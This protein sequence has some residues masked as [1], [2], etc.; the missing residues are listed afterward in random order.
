MTSLRLI[1]ILLC[2]ASPVLAQ[3]TNYVRAGASGAN[4]GSDWA[5]A[6]TSF[7]EPLVR[8]VTYM[9]ADGSHPLP[10]LNTANS[11][12]DR[13]TILKATIANHGTST[14]WDNAYGDGQA[15]LGSASATRG[16]YTIDGQTRNATNWNS[17]YGFKM[18]QYYN[19]ADGAANA[20]HNL[21]LRH[22]EF[23]LDDYIGQN[24]CTN[25][26]TPLYFRGSS[27]KTNILIENCYIRQH[28]FIQL[29]GVDGI[30][31][32]S[33]ALAFGWKKEAIRG[34]YTAKNGVIEW[35]RFYRA[36]NG[37]KDENGGTCVDAGENSH[38]GYIAIWDEVGGNP[39]DNWRIENNNF[40]HSNTVAGDG[41]N[42]AI[43]VGGGTGWNGDPANNVAI[44][45]NTLSGW[46]A[47]NAR[48]IINGGDSAG[49]G[50]EI[51][52][53]GWHDCTET[54]VSTANVTQEGNT[55]L[56]AAPWTTWNEFIAYG[57]PEG[58]A[59]PDVTAPTVSSANINSAGTT[60]TINFDESTTGDAGFTISA[61]GGAATLSSPS[62]S[63]TAA[64]TFTVS[65]TIYSG[66]TVT[67]SY[68]AG[69]VED[70]SENALEN[71]SGA[72]VTNNST[73]D[74][75][76]PPAGNVIRVGT[77]IITGP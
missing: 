19:D 26:I 5:N 22:I 42:G 23:G 58:E 50:K 67:L 43:I 9:V 68:T 47:M 70:A 52:G 75:P 12:S 21:V 73:E 77:L 55:T 74:E 64:R 69:D 51:L 48:L 66:E 24:W 10:A 40:W 35:C 28:S 6:F 41:P 25:E 15:D 3:T 29:A 2:F 53:N 13:I 20:G 14:G 49:T 27:I 56:G 18:S 71:F 60:L 45:T 8:G 39:F 1:L 65:R 17:G 34:Q 16:Q 46:G 76:E 62:G 32:R 7:P 33:N 30:T 63:G 44:N 61:S 36:S 54:G 31:I 11:G 72:A 57:L 59:E 4:D 38:T 37:N